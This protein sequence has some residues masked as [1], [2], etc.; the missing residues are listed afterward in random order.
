M[1]VDGFVFDNLKVIKK[2]KLGIPI[3][4][5]LNDK[6]AYKI[7]DDNLFKIVGNPFTGEKGILT[8]DQINYV[9]AMQKYLSETLGKRG[10]EVS[11][12]MYGIDLFNEENYLPI[13]SEGA[14]MERVRDQ[15]NGKTAKIKNRAHTKPTVKGAHNPIILEHF[16]ELWANHVTSMNEYVA[17]TLPLEDFYKVYN[18]TNKSST[19]SDKQSVIAAMEGGAKK[20][21]E[22]LLDD[23]NGGTR[24]DNRVGIAKTLTGAFKKAKVM[25]STSVVVQQPSS[26]IRAQAVIDPKY[27]VG[28]KL[29]SK[30]HKEAWA[31]LKKYAPVAIIKEMGYFDIGMGQTSAKWLMNEPTK[32]DRLDEITSWGAAKA[33]EVTWLAIWNAVKRETLYTHKDLAPNS[34]AFLKAAGKRFE[35]VIRLTQVYDS[36]LARSSNMRSKDL[37][38]QMAT[39]FLAEPTTSL[40]M[41]GMALRS[42]NKGRIARTMTAV[43]ASAFLNAILVAFPYA[44]RDDDEDETF[45]EK[46][47]SAL[48]SNFVN[49]INPLASIP[50]IRDVWSL[51]QG[52][53]VGRSDMSLADDFIASME[54]LFKESIKE[55]SDP[56]AIANAIVSLVGDFANFTG[57]PLKN[58][59]REAMAFV[60]LGKTI[61][62]DIG[63]RDTTWNSIVD[64]LEETLREDTPI[65]SWLPKETKKEK[66][67]D[68]IQKGDEAYVDRFKASYKDEDSF[69]SAIR[70]EV[71]ERYKDGEMTVREATNFLVKHGGYEKDAENEAYWLIKK[72][73][74]QKK[75][76]KDAEYSKYTE[77]YEAV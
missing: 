23:L 73:D 60:N 48:T 28:K 50:F 75:H 32:M 51:A 62:R 16:N 8:A 49:K 52:Y 38:M 44:A 15:A 34:D 21:L 3:V 27:F 42:G 53:S 43:Y 56:K 29:D 54:R 74:F 67:V 39:S 26:I 2:N 19:E 57:I 31:E 47:L 68:A 4:Y 65:V 58:L 13:L 36:T 10:N 59:I 63:E 6:T 7:D 72:W 45:A 69:H 22:Q 35:K 12:Q 25:F 71:G 77:W 33:D 20:A 11:E 66:L 70:S 24:S 37:L 14:Y 41:Q 9:V 40:N 55:D 5:E 64:A 1:R 17:F 18:Y 76:G 30:K 46:Y 61:Y